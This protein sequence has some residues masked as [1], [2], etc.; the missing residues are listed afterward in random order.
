MHIASGFSGKVKSIARIFCLAYS[1]ANIQARKQIPMTQTKDE[2]LRQMVQPVLRSGEEIQHVAY[3]VKQPNMLLMVPAFFLAIIPGVLLTARL[4]KHYTFALTNQ[5]LIIL[6]MASKM[7]T[8]PKPEDG[9]EEDLSIDL[10]A[11]S[12]MDRKTKSGALF[13]HITVGAVTAKF[14]RAYSK[15]N[16]TSALAMSDVIDAA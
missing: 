3:G 15:T 9:F 11:L 4:T 12:A 14:H 16:R 13:V 5:R 10:S 7:L 2:Q 6:R 8:L 1:R